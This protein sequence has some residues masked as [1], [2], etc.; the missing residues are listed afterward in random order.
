V[1]QYGASD[2]NSIET[3]RTQST[4]Q[5]PNTQPSSDWAHGT[6]SLLSAQKCVN[7]PS[8]QQAGRIC[9]GWA[10]RSTWLQRRTCRPYEFPKA[11]Q[12]I[13]PTIDKE[14]KFIS[15]LRWNMLACP[16]SSKCATSGAARWENR[17]NSQYKKKSLLRTVKL[18]GHDWFYSN[19]SRYK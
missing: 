4:H 12:S 19:A 2:K 15:N 10:W 1:P 6:C 14:R 17:L 7:A 3:I 16:D 11:C 8:T 5:T 9:L 13:W 18:M